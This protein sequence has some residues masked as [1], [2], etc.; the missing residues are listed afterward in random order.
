MLIVQILTV[1]T[2]FALDFDTTVEDSSRK[3]YSNTKTQKKT[4]IQAKQTSTS[5][6]AVG[7]NT[8]VQAPV[9]QE[10]IKEVL[11]KVPSVP[12]QYNSATVVPI[13][14]SYSGK[15]PNSDAMIPCNDIKNNQL[16]ID[17]KYAKS[18]KAIV[19]QEKKKGTKAK[20]SIT[21]P[22]YAAVTS[23]KYRTTTLAKG[24][25]VRAINTIKLSDGMYEGQTVTFLTTQEIY[26]SKFRIP[27]RTKL[28]ARIVDTHLPQMTCNGGLIGI[29]IV[30]ANINGYNQPINASIIKIKTD[31][32]YFSNL[33]GKH[34]YW[35][36]TCK[37]AKWG[38]NIF[39]KW[40]K[41]AKKL[42]NKGACI[43]IAPFPYVTGF[44]TA[45][46]STVTSPVTALLGKGE[47]IIVPV[48]TVFT[49][50]LNEDAKI[51]Y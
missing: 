45:C 46:A 40:S 31:N 41:S 18:N 44:V 2:V 17:E 36:T 10:V 3:N 16:I 15:V 23:S 28:T 14:N 9:Q 13:N 47:R 51:R 12:K 8:D 6:S 20:K 1:A 19:V 32:I 33:K 11:P 37:K 34:T 39:K 21:S 22:T 38:Q 30:S 29:K 50:K 27:A 24:T 35:K 43:I 26:T 4:V 7:K 48:N 49:I 42:A 5:S 25:Q